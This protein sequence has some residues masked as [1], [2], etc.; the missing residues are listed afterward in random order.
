MNWLLMILVTVVMSQ[1]LRGARKE[2][3]EITSDMCMYTVVESNVSLRYD[4]SK[5]DYGGEAD[6]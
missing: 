3:M 1:S 2:S 5:V 4:W 6:L